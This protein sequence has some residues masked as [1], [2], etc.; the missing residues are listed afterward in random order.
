MSSQ[1]I[2]YALVHLSEC[3]TVNLAQEVVIEEGKLFGTYDMTHNSRNIY[4][5]RSK[6]IGNPIQYSSYRMIQKLVERLSDI[7]Y[8]PQSGYVLFAGAYHST[9][10]HQ[11]FLEVCY[12]D[13]PPARVLV[14]DDK[15][16]PRTLGEKFSKIPKLENNQFVLLE[17][18]MRSLALLRKYYNASSQ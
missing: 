16:F 11:T 15:H 2:I 5:I 17:I 13:K 4:Q 8:D 6:F 10:L 14:Y 3:V 12:G 9:K 1:E 7:E 18:F